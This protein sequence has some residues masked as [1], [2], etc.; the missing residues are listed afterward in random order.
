LVSLIIT[1]V[2]EAVQCVTAAYAFPATAE[3][4]IKTQGRYH[5]ISLYEKQL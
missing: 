4:G 1:D 3:W 2:R 5:I